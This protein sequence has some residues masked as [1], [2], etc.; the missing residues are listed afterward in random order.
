MNTEAK[1]QNN[2]LPR[3]RRVRSITLGG[4][5]VSV[6]VLA[7]ASLWG[8]R[9]SDAHVAAV[10]MGDAQHGA[11]L[12]NRLNCYACH[13]VGKRDANHY[14]T[15]APTGPDLR[16][17]GTK[18]T[19]EAAYAYIRNPSSV[20]EHTLMPTYYGQSNNSDVS[21]RVRGEQEVLAMVHYLFVNSEKVDAE[22]PPEGGNPAR[23]KDLLAAKGCMSCHTDGA[24]SLSLSEVAEKFP[25]AYGGNLSNVSRTTTPAWVFSFLKTPKRFAK[26]TAMPDL[27]LTNEEAADLTAY[28]ME[29][30]AST[31]MPR[32]EP[33]ADVAHRGWEAA[34]AID[35]VVI[36]DLSFE[37]LSKTTYESDA[38]RQ[39]NTWDQNA[40]L[41]Y[42]GFRLLKRYGCYGCHSIKGFEDALPNGTDLVQ[43][44]DQHL[45]VVSFGVLDVPLGHYSD[46]R[47]KLHDPRVFEKDL[48]IDPYDRLI[49]PKFALQEREIDDLATF[50]T[51]GETP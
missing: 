20:D 29:K 16:A 19:K 41:Y 49:M 23:G 17:I 42:M 43:W 39:I 46:A 28:L 51:T 11:A 38:I 2:R 22:A 44:R 18:L 6:A 25:G 26:G 13:I 14:A 9:D 36:D 1:A 35:D 5:V 15:H 30:A 48:I 47:T 27:N 32:V 10:K 37:Y 45:N 8:R 40:K 31:R 7:V 21:F 3:F 33:S 50:V 12:A 4:V 24:G 34:P